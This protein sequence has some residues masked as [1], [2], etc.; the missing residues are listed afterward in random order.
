MINDTH[1]VFCDHTAEIHRGNSC[2]KIV[3]QDDYGD[4]IQCDCY[5][6]RPKGPTIELSDT[7]SDYS[8]MKK[9][10]VN[11]I[12][13]RPSLAVWL[14]A[15][16]NLNPIEVENVITKYEENVRLR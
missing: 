2:Y 6:Y 9:I 1:C 14:A 7:M 12:Y 8:S 15:Y 10:E 16:F 4:D 11:S 3:G 13:S 5:E